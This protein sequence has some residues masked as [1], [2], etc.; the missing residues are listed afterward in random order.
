MVVSF[1]TARLGAR[2]GTTLAAALSVAFAAACGSGTTGGQAVPADEDGVAATG[3]ETT[4]APATTAPGTTD[5]PD[6]SDEVAA[7]TRTT[8]VRTP[9]APAPGAM[10]IECAPD[11]PVWTVW[12]T[13]VYTDDSSVC[14][15][16]VH[17]GVIALQDGGTVYY[18][19]LPGRDSYTG[20]S[21]NGIDTLDWGVWGGS[22]A[23]TPDAGQ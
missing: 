9:A 1:R 4:E 13:D 5:V 11:E 20:S 14:T 8:A 17:A 18:Y 6:T 12:G 2:L 16:A 3:P 10:S 7:P 15:A 21:R 23:F 22:F 19:E